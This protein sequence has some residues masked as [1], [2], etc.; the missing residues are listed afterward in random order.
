MSSWGELSGEE[1]ELFFHIAGPEAD[2]QAA[3]ANFEESIHH[4]VFVHEMGIWWQACRHALSARNHYQNE[5]GADR[6]AI[7]DW[8]QADPALASRMLSVF[9]GM[10]DHVSSPLPPGQAIETYFNSHYEQ[11]GHSPDYAWYQSYMCVAAGA[12][13][14]EPGFAT[15]LAETRP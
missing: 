1:R 14:P 7:A 12:E 2:K 6:I 4:F 10:V 8:R 3:R 9:H 5:Y 11:L 15:T 13:K